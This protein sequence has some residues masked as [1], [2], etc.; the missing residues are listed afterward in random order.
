M[1][2]PGVPYY[3]RSITQQNPEHRALKVNVEG[4]PAHDAGMTGRHIET[5]TPSSNLGLL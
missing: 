4:I 3:T 2:K 1:D 5:V